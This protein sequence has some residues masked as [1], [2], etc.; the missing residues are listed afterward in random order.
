MKFWRYY[1]CIITTQIIII[2][3]VLYNIQE[4]QPNIGLTEYIHGKGQA[5]S[6]SQACNAALDE[7][8]VGML[9]NA[10]ST[11][12]GIDYCPYYG[13]ENH[14]ITAPLSI[15]EAAF[16][17]AYVMTIG[18]DFDTFERLF[19]AIYMPQNVYCIHLDK[20]ATNAFKLAVEH[21]TECFPN[22]FIASESEYITYGGISRL[23]A[24]LICMRDLLALDVNWRYVINT[25]DNDF[26]L[27]TNKEIVRYL[28]TLKGK[29]ITPRLESIQKSA[30]RIKYVHVEHRTRTHSLIL[31]KRKK[32]NPPPN[33]LKIHFGS[34]YVALTKQFVQF[35]LLNKIAIEL[36]QWSQDTYCPDEHFW[37]TLNNIP[38]ECGF[39]SYFFFQC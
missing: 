29:N 31:R 12:F 16:P 34:A 13:T 10:L 6:L 15:E 14:Y 3:T 38:G 9:T 36:L 1:L 5:L 32:K 33:Q 28:K 20:K 18:H 37:T 24:E 35:A 27:K 23:R 11:T 39:L 17:L 30:E 7:K 4:H 26:P 22:A 19:R 2:V 21:L 8:T 25:R